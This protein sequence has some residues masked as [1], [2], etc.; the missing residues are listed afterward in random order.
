VNTLA[1]L[2]DPKAIAAMPGQRTIFEET[3]QVLPQTP[4]A[5]GRGRRRVTEDQCDLFTDA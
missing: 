1:P 5:R 2:P 3:G 4:A